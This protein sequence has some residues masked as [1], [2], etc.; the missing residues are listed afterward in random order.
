MLYDRKRR[1]GR[2]KF[3]KFC[4]NQDLVINYKNTDVLRQYM[5]EVG[6]IEPA[7]L[8]GACAKHQRKIANEIKKA[9]HMAL[10][11]YIAD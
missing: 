5:S 6:K 7:R 3:C 11:P 1:Y 2:K 8:T 4:K 10:M 9:R